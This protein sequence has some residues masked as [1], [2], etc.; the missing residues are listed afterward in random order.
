MIKIEVDTRALAES[1]YFLST[2]LKE[3]PEYPVLSYIHCACEKTRIILR[4]TNIE[5]SVV[6]E[7]VAHVES[8]SEIDTFL[9]PARQFINIVTNSTAKKTLLNFNTESM[10]LKYSLDQSSGKLKCIASTDFPLPLY[11]HSESI[12]ISVYDLSKIITQT[13][14]ACDTADTSR[15]VLTG[16]H[17]RVHDDIF[18]ATSGDG[19]RLASCRIRLDRKYQEMQAVIPAKYLKPIRSILRRFD[20]DYMLSMRLP[21]AQNNKAMFEFG[22]TF[23]TTQVMSESFPNV[24]SVFDIKYDQALSI[25]VSSLEEAITIHGS[26]ASNTNSATYFKSN[27]NNQYCMVSRDEDSGIVGT[28]IADLDG[29]FTLPDISFN[30]KFLLDFIKVCG[31]DSILIYLKSESNAIHLRPVSDMASA[32]SSMGYLYYIMP[33]GDQ[34]TVDDQ[35]YLYTAV[36]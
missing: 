25:P 26:Y 35:E 31:D 13:I 19:Y 16:I 9:I 15:V 29:S 6:S 4:S 34:I 28:V 27:K 11:G 32:D 22:G 7:C 1:L 36:P 5:T 24:S 18:E 2:P 3:N 12:R 20:D 30:I 14:I 33:I 17:L 8:D 21:S 23:F 10:S